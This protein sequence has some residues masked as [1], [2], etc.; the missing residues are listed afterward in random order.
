[1]KIV[2]DIY[3]Y[4]GKGVTLILNE[5]MFIKQMYPSLYKYDLLFNNTNKIRLTELTF[6]HLYHPEI[7]V[8]V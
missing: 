5:T 3:V 7:T 6:S 1:L 8:N 4:L 2:Q